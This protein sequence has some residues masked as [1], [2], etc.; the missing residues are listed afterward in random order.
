[1]IRRGG[2]GDE[3]IEQR[4]GAVVFEGGADEHREDTSGANGF[5]QTADDLLIIEGPFLQILHHQLIVGFRGSFDDR[6]AQLLRARLQ[7]GGYGFGFRRAVIISFDDRLHLH[8]VDQ[9]AE[10]GL[11]A[12]GNLH[13]NDRF[14]EAFAQH[15]QRIG[16]VGMFLIHFIQINEARQRARF[17]H[18][19][20]AFGLYFHPGHGIDDD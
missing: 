7:L 2:T 20:I 6:F 5:L 10:L 15:L 9:S 18:A 3:H 12:D 16:E 8:Q 14:A 17:R 11:F 1:M 4:D 13:G 19:P